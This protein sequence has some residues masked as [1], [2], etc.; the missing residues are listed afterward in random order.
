MRVRPENRRL[1]A[2]DRARVRSFVGLS[3]DKLGPRA[4]H[5][6]SGT[7][8]ALLLA[9]RTASLVAVTFGLTAHR[10]VT[11]IVYPL[12]GRWSDRS[13]TGIGRRVPF[14]GGGL[15][16]LAAAT[17]LM[18]RTSGYWMLVAVIVIGR[19]GL[20][21]HG[22]AGVPVTPEVFGG[23]RWIRAAI[24]LGIAGAVV[25]VSIRITLIGT[26]EE[27]D[28]TTWQPAYTLAAMWLAIAGIAVLVLVRESGAARAIAPRREQVPVR[29]LIRRVLATPNAGPL[30]IV[31]LLA[32]AGGGF[33]E[34]AYPIYARDVLGAGADHLAL[35][36]LITAPAWVLTG[37]P[38][39]WWLSRRYDRKT[40]LVLGG[41]SGALAAAAHLFLTNFWHSVAIGIAA[42]PFYT[43]AVIAVLA[44][45]LQLI[46]RA[47]G[48]A[49][50]FALFI[51]PLLVAGMVAAYASGFLVDLIVHDL[52]VIWVPASLCGVGVVVAAMWMRLP[53]HAAH[54]DPLRMIRVG[55]EVLRERRSDG[56][57]FRGHITQH[58][59]DVARLVEDLQDR[60][61]PYV[62]EGVDDGRTHAG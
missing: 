42:G 35:A 6:V 50:R 20:V 33:I 34:R 32:V 8:L 48:V 19:F 44:M 38:L 2:V 57:L 29:K 43:G 18:P 5:T 46:P 55:R 12:L 11:W 4:F 13:S 25:G 22:V 3:L 30:L 26:W 36:G 21:A 52:R 16:V 53:A 23:A 62:D 45:L 1:H 41:L 49:E 9:Q 31:T 51:V 47:G 61:N 59:A 28:P 27:A 56:T 15:L 40:N 60:L 54:A 14:M 58:D 7:F 39:G 17:Y 24:L 37:L 10:L